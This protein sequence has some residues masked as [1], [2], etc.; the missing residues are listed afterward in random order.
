MIVLGFIY[1]APVTI[2]QFI[3]LL[4]GYWPDWHNNLYWYMLLGGIIFVTTAQAK[5][6]YCSWFCPFGAFQECLGVI[7][8]AKIF[9]P[10]KWSTLLTWLPR[11]LTLIAVV[12]GLSLRQ[13]GVAGYEPFA[14]LFDLRGSLFEWVLLALVIL[15]SLV[16]YRPFC[17]FLCPIDPVVDFIASIRR[18]AR[19]LWRKRKNPSQRK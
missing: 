9:R 8:G 2:A 5:N 19:S 3:A 11:G 10:R 18:W 13:P 17:N 7:S 6:P 15:V 12:L 16:M 14:T 1:T 4:S